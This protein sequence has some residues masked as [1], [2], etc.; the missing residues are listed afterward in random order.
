MV[1]KPIN[2]STLLRIEAVGAWLV[3]GVARRLGIPPERAARIAF[4]IEHHG[5]VNAY[6]KDWSD[7]AVSRFVRE[8]GERLDDL[9]AFSSAD[10]TTKRTAKADR[11]QDDLRDLHARLARL[12]EGA[13]APTFPRG[14]GAKVAAL[15]GIAPGPE[16][17]DVM[18][19]LTAE[20]AAGRLPAGAPAAV[21][22]AA[23]RSAR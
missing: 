11:I 16:V 20:V 14:L 18:R 22:L 23:V 4:V 6:E 17:G 12:A 8:A 2:S 13:S 7:R 19:W 15:L 1:M 3:Q 9:L 10:F 21:Y 5:R